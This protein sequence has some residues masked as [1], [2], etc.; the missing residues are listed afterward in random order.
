M[1][2]IFKKELPNAA[3]TFSAE[4]MTHGHA[5]E[6]E[7]EHLHRYVFARAYCRG[8]N[9]LDIA[10]GE[11]YGAAMLAQVATS[12]I[13]VDRCAESVSHANKTHSRPNLEYRM[14]D[15]LKIPLDNASCDVIVSFET[16]EHFYEHDLFM[17]EV[18]RI[19]KPNG[20]LIMSTPNSDIY[21]AIGTPANPYHVN[22][23][24]KGA[25]AALCKKYFKHTQLLQQ[26]AIVG[27]ILL[28]Q[29]R[30]QETPL[31]IET[32]DKDYVE[33]S[34]EWTRAPYTICIASDDNAVRAPD[35]I[36]MHNNIQAVLNEHTFAYHS[37]ITT[38]QERL[39]THDHSLLLRL[40]QMI[41]RM[42]KPLQTLK[43]LLST[44]YA[45]CKNKKIKILS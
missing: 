27:S 31:I 40:D 18:K 12:V 26:R 5:L 33:S 35:S 37:Q 14:G 4:R 44:P 30:T 24:S 42:I 10:S 9:V 13:G 22:E 41:S 1:G 45:S 32:R 43:A 39:T 38:L 20:C 28:S 23:L 8:K 11:G 7:I 19:L 36:F 17:Q 29:Q 6:T 16:L 15:V 3:L 25:F 34:T 21:S 2:E